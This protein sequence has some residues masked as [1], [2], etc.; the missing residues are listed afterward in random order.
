M[1]TV[2]SKPAIYSTYSTTRFYKHDNVKARYVK[3]PE[4]GN[5]FVQYFSIFET[6]YRD[7]ETRSLFN[8]IAGP[9]MGP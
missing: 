5:S 2:F 7:F 8:K 4:Y 6:K 3:L 9:G 1:N